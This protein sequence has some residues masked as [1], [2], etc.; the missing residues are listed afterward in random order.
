M[1]ADHQLRA[2]QCQQFFDAR[3]VALR[4]SCDMDHHY[5]HTFAGENIQFGVNTPDIVAVDIAVNAA[6]R[7]HLFQFFCHFNVAEISSV[8]YFISVAKIFPDLFIEPV[9]GVGNDAYFFQL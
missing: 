9:V 6:Q 5:F 3:R 7:R 4:V 8:P 2:V 1:S